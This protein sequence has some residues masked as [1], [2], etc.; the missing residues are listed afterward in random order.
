VEERVGGKT[1]ADFGAFDCTSQEMAAH[2]HVEY[3]VQRTVG[4]GVKQCPERQL[5]SWK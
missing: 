4:N 3:G 1:A 5:L 2:G